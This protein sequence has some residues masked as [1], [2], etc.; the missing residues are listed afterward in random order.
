MLN[1]SDK[2][3][4]RLSREAANQHDPGA[5]AGSASWDKLEIRLNK[6]LGRFRPNPFRIIRRFPYWYAPVI[7]LLVGVSYYIVKTGKGHNRPPGSNMPAISGTEPTVSPPRTPQPAI[8]PGQGSNQPLSITQ[9]HTYSPTSTPELHKLHK[10][11]TPGSTSSSGNPSASG[12]TSSS[13][14][15]SASANE[16]ASNNT[17]ASG[18]TS[19]TGQSSHRRHPSSSGNGNLSSSGQNGIAGRSGK[20][21]SALSAS[22]QSGSGHSTSSQSASGESASGQSEPGQFP[23]SGLTNQSLSVKQQPAF[24]LVRAPASMTRK[25]T[26]SDSA[27]RAFTVINDPIKK[28]SPSLHVNRRLQFGLLVAPDFSSVNSLAGDRPGSSI[29]LTVD[30]Q[31]FDRWHIGTGLLFTRKI[32]TAPSQDYHAPMDFYRMYNM[33]NVALVKGRFNML[34]IP[35]NIRYDF[36]VYNNTI[37]FVSGGASSYLNANE[38]ASYYFGFFGSESKQFSYGSGNT[39]LFSTINLSLGVETGLSNSLS[40]LIAPYI[41]VPT[42]GIGF[43]DVRMSSV[44]LNVALKFAPVL[45]RKRK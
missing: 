32:Y 31:L 9:N 33:R 18:Y 42:G 19:R 23:A 41:K 37:F 2:E 43:G 15:P 3:L 45:S 22:G 24:S 8:P 36:S 26:V 4:D 34:E 21:A 38:K 11:L 13:G 25:P 16:S 27:L 29:G 10:E 28:K 40:L 44:G 1:L 30:Y 20:S 35:L 39:Y 6:E 5:P 7:L 14:N 17:T 12:S